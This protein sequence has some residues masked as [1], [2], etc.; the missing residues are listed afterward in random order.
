MEYFGAFLIGLTATPSKQTVRF[1]NQNLV[2]EYDH[3]RA[4]A[5]GVRVDADTRNEAKEPH[6]VCDK[7]GRTQPCREATPF[8]NAR[9]ERDGGP[10]GPTASAASSAPQKQC[11]VPQFDEALWEA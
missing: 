8:E 3:E 10:G 5:D 7:A 2:M 6:C 1:F 11:C 4:V 9:L